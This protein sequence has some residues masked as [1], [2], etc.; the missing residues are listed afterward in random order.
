MILFV[1]IYIAS[2]VFALS[3]VFVPIIKHK[4][5]T[6]QKEAL[7]DWRFWAILLFV[8]TLPQVLAFLT[9][10]TLIVNPKVMLTELKKLYE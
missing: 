6:I 2:L 7:K 4:G 3:I 8:L 10:I 5:P 9:I 1:W